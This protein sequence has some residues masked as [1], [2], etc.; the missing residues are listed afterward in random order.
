[1]PRPLEPNQRFPVVLEFDKDKPAETRPTFWFRSLSAREWR[2]LLREGQANESKLDAALCVLQAALVGWDHMVRDGEPV[3]F[4]AAELD[5]IIDTD[6]VAELF[7]AFQLTLEDKKKSASQHL[8]KPAS[9]APD[10]ATV[11]AATAS[12]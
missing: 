10:A 11:N 5:T 1:M 2:K 6:E 4:N 8:S 9:S 12:A 3:P 7:G